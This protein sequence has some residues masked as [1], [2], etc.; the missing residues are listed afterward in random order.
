MGRSFNKRVTESNTSCVTLK[1]RRLRVSHQFPTLDVV[2]LPP[3]CYDRLCRDEGHPNLPQSGIEDC[4]PVPLLRVPL[5]R[6]SHG[7]P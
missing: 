3:A 4:D 5:Q 7:H 1:A 6:T 2:H